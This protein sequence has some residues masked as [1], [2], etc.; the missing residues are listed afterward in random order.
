MDDDNSPAAFVDDE[1]ADSPASRQEDESV[2]AVEMIEWVPP[3]SITV[4]VEAPG[5]EHLEQPP[6]VLASC[7]VAEHEVSP[8]PSCFS[9]SP[10][11]VTSASMTPSSTHAGR[12]SSVATLASDRE[13]LSRVWSSTQSSHEVQTLDLSTVMKKTRRAL[14][15][16]SALSDFENLTVLDVSNNAV[17]DLHGLEALLRLE[18]LVLS[19]NHLKK[20]GTELFSLRSLRDL[21]LSGNFIAH[22]PKAVARLELLERL[23]LSGNSLSTLKEVD[24]LSSLANLHVCNFSANP[25]CKLPTYRDYVVFKL[26]GLESLDAMPITGTARDKARRRFFDVVFAKDAQLR[27]VG[28][29]H[30]S[31]QSRLRDAQSALE[32][33]N[34]RLKGELHVKSQLLQNKSRAWSDATERLLQLQQEIAMLNLERQQQHAALE[35]D[36]SRFS[37]DENEAGRWPYDFVRG[38]RST[39]SPALESPEMP[40][41]A[42][43]DSNNLRTEDQRPGQGSRDHHPYHRSQRSSS[44]WEQ[45]LSHCTHGSPCSSPRN[46][47]EFSSPAPS[48]RRVE[49]SF[50]C[51]PIPPKPV[52]VAAAVPGSAALPVKTNVSSPQVTIPIAERSSPTRWSTAAPYWDIQTDATPDSSRGESPVPVQAQRSE[53]FER[54][55]RA[56]SA[57]APGTASPVEA[58][59][60]IDLQDEEKVVGRYTRRLSQF[61]TVED[62][63]ACPAYE[64]AQTISLSPALASPAASPQHTQSMRSCTASGVDTSTTPFYRASSSPGRLVSS[65]RH[66]VKSP[67]QRIWERQH[68][69]FKDQVLSPRSKAPNTL[70]FLDIKSPVNK[71]VLIRQTQALQSCKQV[72]LKDIAKEEELLHAIK[73][74]EKQF[75]TQIESLE[76]N[77]QACIDAAKADE[78][79]SLELPLSR[80]QPPRSTTR[81]RDDAVL[82]KLEVLRSKLLLVEDREKE[83]EMAMVRKTKR[84]LETDVA[85]V[86][87]SMGMPLGSVSVTD[88]AFDKEIFALTNK[89]QLTIVQKEELQL[90]MARVMELLRDQHRRSSVGEVAQSKASQPTNPRSAA[91]S[92]RRRS[93]RSSGV[94]AEGGMEKDSSLAQSYKLLAELRQKHQD[95]VDRIRV[96]EDL[97]AS[98]VDE[99]RDVEAEL[100]HIGRLGLQYAGDSGVT[101]PARRPR[102][103]SFDF[104]QEARML[105]RLGDSKASLK[106]SNQSP[107]QRTGSVKPSRDT[108]QERSLAAQQ[109]N[110]STSDVSNDNTSKIVSTGAIG[111]AVLPF[112]L[113]CKDL[114][115][116]EM[117]EEIKNEVF[118]KLSE[119]FVALTSSI[120]GA[121][122]SSA[123]QERRELH[124]A[125]ATALDAHMKL[126]MDTY[127]KKKLTDGRPMREDSQANEGHDEGNPKG[128]PGHQSGSSRS[129]RSHAKQREDASA[130]AVPEED[131]DAYWDHFTEL[132]PS[133][134]FYTMKYRFVKYHE[135]LA[136]GSGSKSAASIA[137]TQRILR[138]CERLDAAR[139][140]C[141]T[142]PSTFIEVDPAGNNKS[143][144]KVL[145][146][147]ARDLPTSHLRTKNLDPYVSLEIVYPDLK[148][149]S[150]A[151]VLDASVMP[152]AS[153]SFRSRTQKKTMYPVWDEEFDFSPVRSLNG[154][155]HLR[156]LNDRKLS[157]EQIVGET[158]IPLRT[159][160]HQRRAV[161]WYSLG[162]TMPSSTTSKT[163]QSKV[164]SKI[165]GGAVRLQL[166]LSFSRVEKCKRAVDE[167]VTKFLHEHNHLPPFVEPVDANRDAGQES[168][169]QDDSD[170]SLPILGDVDA[171]HQT[172]QQPTQ[173][174][175]QSW[176]SLS[177]VSN[178]PL[179]ELEASLS[180]YGRW[181][182]D[183][184]H[185]DPTSMQRLVK[186]PATPFSTGGPNQLSTP[187]IYAG[188]MDAQ[189]AVTGAQTALKANASRMP[190]EYYPPERQETRNLLNSPP[191]E[192][193]R[194]ATTNSRLL[195]SEQNFN[196]KSPYSRASYTT[197]GSRPRLDRIK[198]STLPPSRSRRLPHEHAPFQQQHQLQQQPPFHPKP[199][200]SSRRDECFDEYSPYHPA[201][202]FVDLFDGGNNEFV[203]TRR[204]QSSRNSSATHGRH[205]L[206]RKT[207]LRIFKSPGFSRRQPSSGF[208]ERYIG[209]D[210]QTCERLKRMFG[211]IDAGEV[212]AHRPRPSR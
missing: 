72:L 16:L 175:Q 211:R 31:A 190:S 57:V 54:V 197:P 119:Q 86:S 46:P 183:D 48:P 137:G 24:A 59:E 155:L 61:R 78:Q 97:L 110:A 147:S 108:D 181:R 19:R 47:S 151:G 212:A 89:L 52:P 118:A 45:T 198:S 122:E 184:D 205:P 153:Q 116:T 105:L 173:Q 12:S 11:S 141:R 127:E 1:N 138:A 145:L 162:I 69:E 79:A 101:S 199:V 23:N 84:V 174:Q 208:P 39:S 156:I 126:A 75:A 117:L 13:I 76:T 177:S 130:A 107:D 142:S 160:L 90:E 111:E 17:A 179:S 149:Q 27:E 163:R 32:A 154:Y 28:E 191:S 82:A 159:L 125:I 176:Q 115:T 9:Y 93:S 36:T 70:E 131:D 33:E 81:R 123:Q 2:D 26:A 64:D 178:F 100:E 188:M 157:R 91:S 96:K 109:R 194:R 92:P 204:H 38:G 201:F 210:N 158:R 55:R 62:D 124:D 132:S 7:D 196:V 29:A 165:C 5:R 43:L 21:D 168:P 8:S 169:E 112:K 113:Q 83:I 58:A 209:L 42:R 20:I 63:L 166:Q 161:E 74:Q 56:F 15:S 140:E 67:S 34:Q 18:T 192:R 164:I 186:D 171:E 202:Q 50:Q 152:L 195:R 129:G 135:S 120:G 14:K 95:V 53:N 187:S 98:L 136:R 35:K 200:S 144:L 104:H 71:D 37:E 94:V 99:L 103:A 146:M 143:A 88:S 49:V 128:E 185:V 139:A 73:Q 65:P 87:A 193:Q 133:E 206:D 189:T 51:S 134:A 150:K 106:E 85:T 207:D 80:Q 170:S 22:I 3:P 30:E 60:E 148:K 172:N 121:T 44:A 68:R 25:F 4:E 10:D 41:R 66:D 77:I 102:S 6:S 180:A 114:L 40:A 203:A 167:L 182:T